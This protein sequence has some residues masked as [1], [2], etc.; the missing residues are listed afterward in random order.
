MY[1]PAYQQPYPGTMAPG[2]SPGLYNMMP[3]GMQMMPQG[4]MPPGIM[5]PPVVV[6]GVPVTVP[7]QTT[8]QTNQ[9]KEEEKKSKLE[10]CGNKETMNLQEILYINI[11]ASN[12][13]KDLYRIKTY[14]E[15]ID[16]IYYQV[17]HLG[18]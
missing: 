2:Y 16:E 12:Y 8:E 14:H 1:Y 10:V 4:M 15:I 9:E 11:K 6:G 3:Q 13:F 5:M 17:K 7:V 18:L